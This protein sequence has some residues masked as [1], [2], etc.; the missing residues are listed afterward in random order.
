MYTV[1][2]SLEQRF[3][4]YQNR[5]SSQFFCRDEARYATR[6]AGLEGQDGPE[7]VGEMGEESE[8]RIY[9]FHPRITHRM[10]YSCL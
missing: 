8:N 9:F 7:G 2:A 10:R 3:G 6:A 1:V 5:D 4:F